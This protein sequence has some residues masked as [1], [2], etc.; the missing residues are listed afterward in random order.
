M[1]IFDSHNIKTSPNDIML[2]L[3]NDK[4]SN[5]KINNSKNKINEI[6]D[7]KNDLIEWMDWYNT[8]KKYNKN[9]PINTQE[10]GDLIY[11]PEQFVHAVYNLED[12]CGLV[13]DLVST[14]LIISIVFNLTNYI[15]KN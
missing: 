12:T 3:V 7:L 14:V 6:F 8:Y 4:K 9:T 15:F 11:V 10:A 1:D 13:V 2:K 5:N